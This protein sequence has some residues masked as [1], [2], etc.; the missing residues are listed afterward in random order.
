MNA[1]ASKPLN[2][3]ELQLDLYCRGIRIDKSC[4]LEKDSR[5]F[6]RTR[7]GLGSGLELVI[8]G[9]LKEIWTNVPVEEAFAQESPYLLVKENGAYFVVD[10]RGPHRYAVSVPAQPAWYTEKTSSGRLM[11]DIGVLQGTYLGIYLGPPCGYWK[12]SWMACK[13]CTSGENVGVNEA[14]EKSIDDVVETCR[15]AKE[16]SGVTFVHFNTGFQGGDRDLQMMAPYVKAVKERVG[17]IV[18]IQ[19]VPAKSLWLYDWLIDLGADHFSFCFEFYNPEWFA[20]ICPGKDKTLGLDGYFRAMEYTSKKMGKG[21][22]SGEIIAGVEPIEDTLAAIDYIT[23]VGAFPT[24]CVFRPLIGAEMEEYPPP[25][26]EDMVVVFRHM[27]DACRKKGIPIG[28]A[29]NIE[30]SL[31]CQPTDAVYLVPYR[32]WSYRLYAWKNRAL[33]WLAR[34]HFRRL[35]RPRRVRDRGMEYYRQHWR[36]D[37]PATPKTRAAT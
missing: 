11:M 17:L 27:Y 22:V 30:V 34:P 29:P 5:S 31:I 10:E 9:D 24:V 26:F 16:E 19:A 23:D 8:P 21:A 15:R 37:V 32:Q 7:A 2:P 4:T 13:F 6:S 1:A 3:C 36:G 33:T 25:K 12:A 35:L 14:L 18:G 28:I 20:K